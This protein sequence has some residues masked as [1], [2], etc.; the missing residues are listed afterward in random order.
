MGGSPACISKP[1]CYRRISLLRSGQE[2]GSITPVSTRVVGF[3][4]A[5]EA[6]GVIQVFFWTAWLCM[7]ILFCAVDIGHSTSSETFHV[8]HLFDLGLGRPL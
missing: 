8:E 6:I 2:V 5:G 1:V 7:V 3:P 4:D